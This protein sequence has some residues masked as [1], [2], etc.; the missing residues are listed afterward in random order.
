MSDELTEWLDPKEWQGR[1]G[2][3]EAERMWKT[4]QGYPEDFPISLQCEFHPIDKLRKALLDYSAAQQTTIV[5]LRTEISVLQN[6]YTAADAAWR[7]R[8]A[9]LE[10]RLTAVSAE[11]D[12]AVRVANALTE[13]APLTDADT[14]WATE[15]L[16][17][18]DR[19]KA[20][21]AAVIEERDAALAKVRELE[22]ALKTRLTEAQARIERITYRVRSIMQPHIW[23]E[24]RDGVASWSWKGNPRYCLHRLQQ[25]LADEPGAGEEEAQPRG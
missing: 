2:Y 22:G 5:Q 23:V 8:A 13:P 17:V 16:S 24:L 7:A 3:A 25:A 1:E 18:V 15:T 6:T 9:D 21:L 12:A 19:L 20:Q 14:Q 11:K 4:L 10:A